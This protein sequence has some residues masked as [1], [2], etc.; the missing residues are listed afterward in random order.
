MN[1]TQSNDPPEKRGSSGEWARFS[2]SLLVALVS[3]RI[4]VTALAL[5]S[6]PQYFYHLG[7]GSWIL[8]MFLSSC[9]F[10]H[11]RVGPFVHT[12]PLEPEQIGPL[13]NIGVPMIAFPLAA[14]A[15]SRCIFSCRR[16]RNT[17]EAVES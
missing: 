3:I 13:I 1:Y 5:P 12:F 4:A 17:N 7:A 16:N 9:G 11:V 15:L 14:F 10:T 2:C 8:F 6:Q